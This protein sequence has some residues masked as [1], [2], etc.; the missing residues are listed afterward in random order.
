MVQLDDS[1]QTSSL[2][3]RNV[4]QAGAI[5]LLGMSLVD[6]ARWRAQAAEAGATLAKPKSVIYVFLTGGPSQHDT[7]DMKPEGPSEYKGEFQ[8]IT[9]RHREFR[10]ANT[11]HYWPSVPIAGLWSVR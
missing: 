2:S 5:G 4:L 10:F 11:S 3:R 8:P 7:F 6:V 9:R 1:R